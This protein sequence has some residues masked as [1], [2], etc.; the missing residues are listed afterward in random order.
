MWFLDCVFR[1]NLTAV[2][3][4]L[5]CV[6]TA[7]AVGGDVSP[8]FGWFAWGV[9]SGVAVAPDAVEAAARK[10]ARWRFQRWVVRGDHH[11]WSPWTPADVIYGPPKGGWFHIQ[12]IV[13]RGHVWERVR[14]GLE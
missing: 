10:I 9:F 5:A 3:F 1:S 14:V 11:E 12:S 2:T 4:G 7:A 8:R 13:R 6:W